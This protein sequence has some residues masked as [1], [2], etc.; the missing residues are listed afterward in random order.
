MDMN[1]IIAMVIAL[2]PVILALV[3]TKIYNIVHGLVSYLFFGAL[4]M[5]CL[6]IFG[7]SMPVISS[8]L[9]G[10]FNGLFNGLATFLCQPTEGLITVLSYVMFGWIGLGDIVVNNPQVAYY[11]YFI[12]MALIFLGSQIISSCIFRK[13]RRMKKSLLK[14]AKRY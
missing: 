7:D 8:Y 4:L 14:Q 12:L 2:L 9:V 13:R 6:L 10:Y 1:F 3:F 5:L 11:V